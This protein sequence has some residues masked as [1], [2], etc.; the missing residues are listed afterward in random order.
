MSFFFAKWVHLHH[1]YHCKK[2]VNF[3][4]DLKVVLVKKRGVKIKIIVHASYCNFKGYY[5][6]PAKSV[7]SEN[8]RHTTHLKK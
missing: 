1:L 2:I 5:L 3:R 7:V 8:F 6:H 4:G